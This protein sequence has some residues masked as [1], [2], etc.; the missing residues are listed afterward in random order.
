MTI[1][2]YQIEKGA[3]IKK[4]RVK[5]NNAQSSQGI[6]VD[7]VADHHGVVDLYT[8]GEKKER[9]L[10]DNLVISIVN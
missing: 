8:Y 3:Q 4:T 7:D 1:K 2:T 9:T 10:A 5:G 6:A